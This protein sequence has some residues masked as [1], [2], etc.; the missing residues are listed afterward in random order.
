MK[1]SSLFVCSI[2]LLSCAAQKTQLLMPGIDS[3]TSNH[4]DIDKFNKQK[5]K[6]NRISY[7]NDRVKFS[8]WHDVNLI[9]SP[10]SNYYDSS[11]NE[12]ITYKKK[13]IT[14]F[15]IFYTTGIL[16]ERGYLYYPGDVP[17]GVWQ[18]FDRN[19]KQVGTKD[20]DKKHKINYKDALQIARKYYGYRQKNVSLYYDNFGDTW[21]VENVKGRRKG[22]EEVHIN[23]NTG[24][25]KKYKVGQPQY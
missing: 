18:D 8:Q 5:N 4:F 9:M 1:Y 17:I 13:Y 19:G 20:F 2:L 24:E 10:D 15:K 16:N 7:E 21:W 22:K 11:Y 14:T 6:N 23:A 3:T 25:H 12:F